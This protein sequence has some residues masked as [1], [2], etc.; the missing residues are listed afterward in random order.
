MNK[1]TKERMENYIEEIIAAYADISPK[2]TKQDAEKK[3]FLTSL[4]EVAPPEIL[5]GGEKKESAYSIDSVAF[6]YNAPRLSEVANADQN[7]L[8]ISIPSSSQKP[9][10]YAGFL[11]LQ[12]QPN[13]TQPNEYAVHPKNC[14]IGPTGYLIPGITQFGMYGKPILSQMYAIRPKFQE[15]RYKK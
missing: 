3:D 8:F 11:F 12:T 5:S 14:C 10:T 15:E 1:I 4:P 13:N 7:T 6:A 2:N 9:D